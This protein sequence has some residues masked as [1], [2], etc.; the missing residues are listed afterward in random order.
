MGTQWYRRTTRLQIDTR[1]VG[2]AELTITERPYSPA[3]GEE[4]AAEPANRSGFRDSC[5]LVDLQDRSA[6]LRK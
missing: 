1:L 3:S 6:G 4:M 2:R 5:D